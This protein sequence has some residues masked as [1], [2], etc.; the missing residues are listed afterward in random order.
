MC[1]F[2]ICSVFQMAFKKTTTN[3][4]KFQP[5]IKEFTFQNTKLQEVI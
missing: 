1:V 4:G 3:L 5:L 2:A